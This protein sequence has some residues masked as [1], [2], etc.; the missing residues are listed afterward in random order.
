M[1][2][3]TDEELSPTSGEMYVSTLSHV[4]SKKYFNQLVRDGYV[5]EG[6][7]DGE[8]WTMKHEKLKGNTLSFDF[9]V[10]RK[11]HKEE[12]V[13]IIKS[14]ILNLRET[15][16]YTIPYIKSL[17][18]TISTSYSK[19]DG[20]SVKMVSSFCKELKNSDDSDATKASRINALLNFFSY[21]DLQSG[22]TYTPKL[23]E[24]RNKLKVGFQIRMLPKSKNVLLFEDYLNKFFEDI[25][26]KINEAGLTD[27]LLKLKILF[28]PI[29]IWWKLTTKIPIRPSEFCD[30]VRECLPDPVEE[31]G[32]IKYHI[33]LPREKLNNSRIQILDKILIDK[34]LRDLINE[35]IEMTNEYGNTE[36]L[37]SY[38]SLIFADNNNRDE[39]KDPD[40]FSNHI[41]GRLIKKFY[42]EVLLKIYQ[43]DFPKDQKITPYHSRHIAFVNLMLQGISP[44]EIARLGGHQTVQAQYHYSYHHEY[45]VDSQVHQLMKKYKYLKNNN[46]EFEGFISMVIKDK[47]YPKKPYKVKLKLREIGF[48]TDELQRCQSSECMLCDHWGCSPEEFLEKQEL[49]KRKLGKRRKNIDELIDMIQKLQ[50]TVLSDELYRN[51]VDSFSEINTKI[52]ELNSQVDQFAKIGSYFNDEMFEESEE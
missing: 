16:E 5:I 31:D 46:K 39:K 43:I 29:L 30:I 52:N 3:I 13:L 28:F 19:T 35:Y 51:S 34:E 20:F 48:C 44:I 21:S 38:R 22:E 17:F 24:L 49:I 10:F 25:N 40:Y 6:T 15:G 33:N 11:Y 18:H 23:I 1:S 45:W 7:F 50:R 8:L 26:Q 27:E 36:T 4:Q 12:F 47:A 9:T 41:L 2:A 14:W 37:I 42:N 32:E